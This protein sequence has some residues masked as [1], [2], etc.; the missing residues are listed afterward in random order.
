MRFNSQNAN[1][2]RMD[3]AVLTVLNGFN[4]SSHVLERFAKTHIMFTQLSA[5]DEQDLISL[6][7]SDS[8]ARQDMLTEFKNLEGQEAHLDA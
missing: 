7:V 5:L 6:G 3:P 4:L 8:Q 1:L 2:Q